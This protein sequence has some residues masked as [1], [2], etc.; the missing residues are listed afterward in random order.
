MTEYAR[1]AIRRLSIRGFRSIRSV[2]LEGIPDLVVLHGPNGAGKSNLLLA[3]QFALRAPMVLNVGRDKVVELPLK[4][5]EELLGLRPEDFHYG[6]SR[7]I[8]VAIDV[9][10][11]T[12][13][14]EMMRVS[15]GRLPKLI[16][17]EVV[18]ELLADDSIRGW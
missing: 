18:V 4:R 17:M 14:A 3:A 10:V 13:A 12:K 7:E 2:E 9:E 5:A 16:S 15:R 1:T 8:R 6:G 11:G